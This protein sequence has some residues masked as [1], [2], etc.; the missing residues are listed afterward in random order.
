VVDRVYE[1]ERLNNSQLAALDRE[2]AIVL[3][4][5]GHT[6]QHGPH[7]PHGTTSFAVRRITL[8]VAE[9]L[10]MTDRQRAVVILPLLPYGADSPDQRRP[11]L[12]PLSSSLV[13]RPETLQ[14]VVTDL[15]IGVLR[16]RFRWLFSVG[17]HPGPEYCRAIQRALKDVTTRYPNLLA[18]DTFS[19][20]YAG[21]EANAAPDL[22]TLTRRRISPVE[23]EALSMPAHGGTAAT[24]IMLALDANLVA[25]NYASLDGVPEESI[26]QADDWP[27]YFGGAPALAEADLGRAVMTQLAYRTAALIRR[28]LAGES[29]D[30]LPIYPG[31]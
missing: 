8:E 16:N 12:F 11:D 30:L 22:R 26:R 14:A 3:L 13:L 23:Q 9:L 4:P 7:L 29:L 19:Y 5:L 31:G 10:T 28:A 24:A 20:L 2:R 21:A 27:G 6:Q 15:A 25:R 17:F 1:W 18:V